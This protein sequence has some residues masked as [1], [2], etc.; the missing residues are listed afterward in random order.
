[1][2]VENDPNLK[3][4]HELRTIHMSLEST[5]NYF[6]RKTTADPRFV[7]HG[8]QAIHRLREVCKTLEQSTKKGMAP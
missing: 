6:E 8:R 7:K 1:M 4:V 5:L 2:K 3:I